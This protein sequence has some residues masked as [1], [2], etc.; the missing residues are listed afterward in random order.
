MPV[1]DEGAE[2]RG[3]IADKA[4]LKSAARSQSLPLSTRSFSIASPFR[5]RLSI[6][7]SSDSVQGNWA[8]QLFISGGVTDDKLRQY[9]LC[10]DL[11]VAWS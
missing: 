5:L 1:Q 4:M 10:R 7:R 2:Q 11:P 3:G 8:I 9:C 6:K